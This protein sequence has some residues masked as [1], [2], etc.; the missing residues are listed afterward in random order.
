MKGNSRKTGKEQY[1]TKPFVVDICVALSKEIIKTNYIIEPCAGSGEFTKKLEKHY[2]VKSY[3]LEPIVDG[4]EERNWFDVSKE[5]IKE[6][7]SI[8]TNPPFGRMNKLSVDFFNH[9]ADLGAKYIAFLI[10]VSWYKWTTQN[11]L[12]PNYH[13]VSHMVLPNDIL[14]YGDSVDPDRKN[15]LKCCFQIWERQDKPREKHVVDDPKLLTRCSPEDA[16]IE[17][18][19]QGGSAGKVNREFGSINKNGYNYYKASEKTIKKL[20]AL[21]EMDAYRQFIDN[22]AY[23]PSIS[24]DEIN[25]KLNGNDKSIANI[26]KRK[27]R[28]SSKSTVNGGK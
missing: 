19:H 22:C 1:Y 16:D 23:V 3:D 10:P 2:S 5:D 8:I 18:V 17:F 7:F 25:F 26:N 28:T 21:H 27:G 14:F 13:L 6:E 11:R 9:A 20:E 24:L 4:I 15:I 12:D